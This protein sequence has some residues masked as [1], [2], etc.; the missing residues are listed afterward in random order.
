M[1]GW[2]ESAACL[3]ASEEFVDVDL[4]VN[5]ETTVSA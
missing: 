2:L 1:T 5:T 3:G 4:S